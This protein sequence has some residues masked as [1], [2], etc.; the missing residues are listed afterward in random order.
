MAANRLSK[1]LAN[2][3]IASRRKCEDLIFAGKIK[4][5][6]VIATLPQMQ[7]DVKKDK[8]LVE[9]K[10]L[11]K[12]E[13]KVYFLFNKP[14][15]FLCTSLEVAKEKSVLHFF[16]E[17]SFRL[18]TVGRLDKDTKGLLIVTNDG[19]FAQKVIHPSKNISK[20]YLAKTDKDLTDEHLKALATGGMVEGTW[21]KPIS[22]KKVRKGTV[23]IAVGEG[24]K[25]RSAYFI[26]KY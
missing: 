25:A 7:V 5:N 6:G 22:V 23:K 14:A 10:E 16:K 26:R 17:F 19:H 1:V 2:C 11:I 24:K 9:G 3:G 20:E 4:V 13:E 21:V 8:I 15:G 12:S 18:F